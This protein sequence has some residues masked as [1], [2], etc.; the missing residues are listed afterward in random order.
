M[1]F[2]KEIFL[3]FNS[4]LKLFSGK[5]HSRWPG[6]FKVLNVYP[7]GVIEIDTDANG[8]FKVNDAQLKH[9]IAGESLERK[10]TCALFDVSSN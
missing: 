2:G 6:P 9:Y 4:R 7:Y 5:L 8:S 1:S 10:V 3:L